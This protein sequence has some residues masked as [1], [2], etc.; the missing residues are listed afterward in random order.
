MTMRIA[1]N[2]PSIPRRQAR[3]PP[4]MR[5]KITP[6]RERELTDARRWRMAGGPEDRATYACACGKRFEAPVSTSVA[7]PTCGSGQAW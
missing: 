6:E 1:P 4:A 3:R 2:R 5:A 7:C